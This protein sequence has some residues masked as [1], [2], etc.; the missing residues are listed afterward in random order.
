MSS[1]K[2]I[3]QVLQEIVRLQD[4]IKTENTTGDLEPS[5]EIVQ[6]VEALAKSFE[7]LMQPPLLCNCSEEPYVKLVIEK[8]LA[9]CVC[10]DMAIDALV[11]MCSHVFC[12]SCLMAWVE[13]SHLKLGINPRCP[14][15]LKVIQM[16]PFWMPFPHSGLERG[17]SFT[18]ARI[19]DELIRCYFE[20]R[21]IVAQ[22]QREDLVMRRRAEMAKRPRSRSTSSMPTSVHSMER[23]KSLYKIVAHDDIAV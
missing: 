2:A 18:S 22:N 13:L 10:H 7:N 4:T 8:L 14:K 9:C 6:K 16:R 15:C 11:L 19:V 12:E 3:V 1:F 20:L 23:V 17:T 5:P 21:C